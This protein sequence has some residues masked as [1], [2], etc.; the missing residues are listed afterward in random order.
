M[1]DLTDLTLVSDDTYWRLDSSNWGYWWKMVKMV[2]MKMTILVV[3]HLSGDI[4]Y[5]L[6]K[7]GIVQGV[8]ACDVLPAVMFL[9]VLWGWSEIRLAPV[10][11]LWISMAQKYK[12][13]GTLDA[14]FGPKINPKEI[15]LG[16]MGHC[17]NESWLNRSFQGILARPCSTIRLFKE[18]LQ[19]EFFCLQCSDLLQWTM[20]MQCCKSTCCGA[21]STQLT[22]RWLA[23]EGST[24]AEISLQ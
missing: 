14:L 12:T 11:L 21:N 7:V 1:A 2:K 15:K 10:R 16:Y 22:G 6:I 8:I 13:S 24:P 4:S 23:S 5:L 3:K 9:L 19:M 18:M 17:P 20:R